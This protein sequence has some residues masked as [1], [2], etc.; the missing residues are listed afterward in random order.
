MYRLQYREEAIHPEDPKHVRKNSPVPPPVVKKKRITGETYDFSLQL[1][2]EGK[3]LEDIAEDRSMAVS[4]IRS[5][6]AKWI[7][8]GDI[9]VFELM[10]KT[11]AENIWKYMKVSNAISLSDFKHEIPFEVDYYELR[12][13]RGHFMKE[14]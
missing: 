3:S 10:D 12:W 2:K 5:H 11:R 4:T 14:D 9:S 1:F 7:K 8:T 13:V 6:M